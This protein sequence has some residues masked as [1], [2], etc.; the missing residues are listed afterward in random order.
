MTARGQE[1]D[2]YASGAAALIAGGEDGH[3]QSRELVHPDDPARTAWY[4]WIVVEGEMVRALCPVRAVA[5]DRRAL[6]HQICTD[7]NA[8]PP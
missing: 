7:Y 3:V 2:G 1:L 4:V 5:D 8:L 6:G